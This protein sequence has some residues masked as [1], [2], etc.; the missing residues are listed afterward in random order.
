V[1]TEEQLAELEARHKKI[2][3]VRW[4]EHAIVFRRPT[5]DECRLYRIAQE[6]PASKADA[7]EQVCQRTIVAFD[8]DLDPNRARERF[9]GTFLVEHPMFSVTTK[10]KSALGA[11][12][13]LVEDEDM[14]DLGKGVTL[15]PAPRKP[16]PEGSR[17]G[18]ATSPGAST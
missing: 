3:I 4:N 18:S 6:E 15:R 9:T 14:L 12:M 16:S 8:D 10:V 11:L 7:L 2:A 17:S 5:R 1:P 13:G